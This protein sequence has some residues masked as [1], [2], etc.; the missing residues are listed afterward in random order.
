MEYLTHDMQFSSFAAYALPLP[1]PFPAMLLIERTF[2]RIPDETN[3]SIG[4]SFFWQLF[5]QMQSTRKRN[6]SL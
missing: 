6:L 1:P 5:E 4:F 3:Y 2:R